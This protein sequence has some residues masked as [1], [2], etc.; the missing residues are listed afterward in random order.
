MLDRADTTGTIA[1]AAGTPSTRAPRRRQSGARR[2]RRDDGARC[3]GLRVRQLRTHVLAHPDRDTL[4]RARLP[5][6]GDC[7]SR[8]QPRGDAGWVDDATPS[9]AVGVGAAEGIRMDPRARHDERHGRDHQRRH[10]RCAPTQHLHRLPVA[11][12]V[13]GRARVLPRMCDLRPA[14]APGPTTER[15]WHPGLRERRLRSVATLRG[16]LGE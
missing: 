13:G 11:D 4:V 1:I 6:P 10:P 8:A 2:R 3:G 9:A 15:R 12:V 14:G 16:R 5:H 7:G